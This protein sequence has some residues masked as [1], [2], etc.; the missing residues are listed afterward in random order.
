MKTYRLWLSCMVIVVVA[1][2][3][4]FGIWKED[5]WDRVAVQ[6]GPGST[7]DDYFP[8]KV[9]VNYKPLLQ[10]RENVG[11]VGLMLLN[12]R[13]GDSIITSIWAPT[14]KRSFVVDWKGN[15]VF[16]GD[17]TNSTPGEGLIPQFLHDN[18]SLSG[19][20]G[21]LRMR[22]GDMTK[23]I[24]IPKDQRVRA[25]VLDSNAEIA[26]ARVY[27][28]SSDGKYILDHLLCAHMKSLEPVGE[29]KMPSTSTEVWCNYDKENK[30]LIVAEA[31]WKWMTMIDIEAPIPK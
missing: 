6:S 20:V 14:A 15:K 29:I 12:R 26:F 30:I 24:Q 18:M 28:Q 21:D 27:R 5:D 1:M 22:M 4:C 13:K 2:V 16:P 10:I 23:V 31:S 9:L 25:L 11:V 8:C 17:I 7:E 19:G 3:A